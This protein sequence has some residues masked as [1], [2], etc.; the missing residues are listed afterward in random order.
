[1]LKKNLFKLILCY[2]QI[3]VVVMIIVVMRRHWRSSGIGVEELKE[4]H[5]G[6][7]DTDMELDLGLDMWICVG[8]QGFLSACRPQ[9]THIIL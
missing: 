1:M 3:K 2:S 7:H 4:D 8:D 9:L 6:F 5:V